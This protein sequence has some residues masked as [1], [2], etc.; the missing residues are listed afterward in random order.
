MFC[1]CTLV[2]NEFE[3]LPHLYQQHKDWPRLVKWIFVESA[4]REYAKAAPHMVS[5]QGLS[6]D[7]TT[8]FLEGLSKTDDRIIHI[9]HGFSNSA[10]P[11]Q[12]KCESRSKYLETMDEVHKTNYL[13]WFTVLD[14]DEFYTRESQSGVNDC[15]MRA[16]RGFYSCMFKQRQIWRSPSMVEQPLL[17]HEVKG[18]F[19]DIPHL[20]CYKFSPGLRYKQNHNYPETPSGILLSSKMKRFDRYPNSPECVHMGYAASEKSRK[21]KHLYYAGRG[22][23]RDPK[24]GWYVDSRESWFNYKPGDKLPRDA[25]VVVYEGEIPECFA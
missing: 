12:G 5:E 22:E 19:W 24:R 20:R 9:K 6:V 8:D 2:L 11:A 4:D 3:W 10:D 15:M 7:G 18:G 1:L 13:R 14:A 17:G 23:K 21:A 16:C 25:Q